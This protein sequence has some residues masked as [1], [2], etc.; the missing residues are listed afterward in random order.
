MAEDRR[1]APRQ[2][3][4]LSAA[5]ETGQGKSRIAITRDISSTGMLIL[6]GARLVVGEVIKLTVVIDEAQRSLSARVVRQ[7]RL[8]PHELWRYKVAIAVDGEDPVLAQVQAT[9]AAQA[10]G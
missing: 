10:S 1:A 5:L 6:V 4:Y 3:A 9:L 7:E 8:E 2:E